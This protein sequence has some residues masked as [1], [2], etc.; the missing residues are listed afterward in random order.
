METDRSS[1]VSGPKKPI[2]LYVPGLILIFWALSKAPEIFTLFG[3][4]FREN[5]TNSAGEFY[6]RLAVDLVIGLG[7]I[8][9]VVT[10][11][12]RRK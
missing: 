3:K 2:P 6:G 4:T 12:V 5:P 1:P 9:L 8:A 10:Y 7:G 11:F